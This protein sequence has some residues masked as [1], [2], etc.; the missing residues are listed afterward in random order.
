MLEEQFLKSLN[1]LDYKVDCQ[2]GEDLIILKNEEEVAR[3]SA[4]QPYKMNTT[5]CPLKLLELI[6]NFSST[7]YENRF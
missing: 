6:V 7:K 5:H 1:E 2:N 4:F 3:V